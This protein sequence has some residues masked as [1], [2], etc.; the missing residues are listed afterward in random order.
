MLVNYRPGWTAVDCLSLIA[1]PLTSEK[2]QRAASVMERTLKAMQE[3]LARLLELLQSSEADKFVAH[4][5]GA[6]AVSTSL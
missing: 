2:K 5:P 4:L 1:H 6:E 3:T